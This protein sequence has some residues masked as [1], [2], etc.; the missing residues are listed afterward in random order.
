MKPSE[1]TQA[2]VAEM[3]S[4]ESPSTMHIQLWTQ[5]ESCPEGTVPILRVQKH[6]L[7]NAASLENYGRKPYHGVVQREVRLANSTVS[8]GSSRLHE[9]HIW[10]WPFLYF[11]IDVC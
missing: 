7:I 5:N 9:V 11:F 10:A 3:S 1:E 4:T 8:L 2:K 6:H